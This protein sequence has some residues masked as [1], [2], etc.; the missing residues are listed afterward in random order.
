MIRYTRQLLAGFA[1]LGLVA[2]PTLRADEPKGSDAAATPAPNGFHGVIK[3]QKPDGTEETFEFGEG[4]EQKMQEKLREIEKETSKQM[5]ARGVWRNMM[6]KPGEAMPMS[7]WGL[8]VSLSP[9]APEFGI[10]ISGGVPESLRKHLKIAE[11]EGQLIMAIA[12]ESPA[13]KAGLKVDDI[14]LKAGNTTIK[15]YGDLVKEVKAAG[16]KGQPLSLEVISEGERK[17][18][19]AT[20]VKSEEIKWSAVA[21]GATL[22]L[23][24]PGEDFVIRRVHPGVQVPPGGPGMMFNAPLPGPDFEKRL[25]HMEKMMQDI[26]KQL[27]Q[28]R[29]QSAK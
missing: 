29:K 12:P 11:G 26:S 9:A 2:V 27:E 4:E 6:V 28:L 10:A 25:E 14:L 13:E 5:S 20:P 17:T 21:E 22:P 19:Q 1:L 15:S 23:N 18:L 3:T 7:E 24:I 16:E 8:G